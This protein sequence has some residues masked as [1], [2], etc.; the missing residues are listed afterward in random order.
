MPLLQRMDLLEARH[1]PTL[2]YTH[3]LIF[4]ATYQSVKERMLFLGE[5]WQRGLR[6]D[7]IVLL[8][9]ARPITPEEKLEARSESLQTESDIMLALWTSL[10]LPAA[11]KKV[12]KILV[13]SPMKTDASGVLLRPNTA[14]TIIAWLNTKPKPGTVVA[15]SNQPYV[16]YQDAV[17]RALMPEQF[18]LS[19][20]GSK[21]N[22]NNINLHLDNLARIL[23][24]ENQIQE[25][26]CA[27]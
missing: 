4:G 24:Q 5:E 7:E 26:Q 11:L 6:F 22:K 14:D 12:P 16:H 19:T 9:S 1:A 23:Y 20:I 2:H 18:S 27:R 25:K 13:H 21:S 10:P 17:L 3:A 8:G 15:I